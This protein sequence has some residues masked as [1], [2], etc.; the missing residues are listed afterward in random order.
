MLRVFLL[1]NT[2]IGNSKRKISSLL[3]PDVCS[4]FSK[5]LLSVNTGELTTNI[6]PSINS[7]IVKNDKDSS[8]TAASNQTT[9]KPLPK[10]P[11]RVIGVSK[12]W[13]SAVP[14]SN[15]S[16]GW[17]ASREEMVQWNLEERQKLYEEFKTPYFKDLAEIKREG[18]KLWEAIPVLIKE[19][20]AKYMPNMK[21]RSLVKNNINTTEILLGKTS[22]VTFCFNK[23]GE[24]HVK[25]FTDPFLDAFS[26]HPSIQLVSPTHIFVFKDV[27]Y[28]SKLL[29]L[30]SARGNVFLADAKCLIRW[31]AHGKAT[32]DEINSMIEVTKILDS[33]EMSTTSNNVNAIPALHKCG[34]QVGITPFRNTLLFSITD[35]VGALD[36]CLAA[37]KS[38]NISLKRIE[39]RPSKTPEW[40]YEF[41]I[42]FDAESREQLTNVVS[43]L[44][45]IARHVQIISSIDSEA[46]EKYVPWF[47]RK[48]A[49]LDTFAEKVLEMGEELTSDHPGAK[50]PVYRARRAEIT[51]IAKTHRHGQPIP[52]IE[53]TKEEVETW[54]TVFRN[55]AKL[56]PTHA[57]REHQ[58]VFPLLVENCRYR[59][60][61]IPQLEDISRFLKDCTGFTLRPVMGLLTSRDFLNGLAFRVFHST[62]YI[63]HHSK[64]LYTPE[65]DICHELLGHANFADF[66]QE[67]GL[68][69]LGASD[70]DIEK[71]ATIYWFTV[72]FGLCRQ[73]GEIRAYGAGLLSSFG[74]LEYAL[75]DKPEK[76]PF[77]PSKTAV[78]K[79]IVT[80]YQP[81]YFV[82]ESFKDAQQKVRD[83][84]KTLTRPFSVRYN[85][86]TESVE[87]LDDKVKILRFAQNIKSDFQ[88]LLDSLES[89]QC[90]SAFLKTCIRPKCLKQFSLTLKPYSYSRDLISFQRTYSKHA[91]H[92]DQFTEIKEENPVKL[93][94]LEYEPPRLH[95]PHESPPLVIL[96]GLFGSK[97]NWKSLAKAFAQRLNTKDLRN[98]GESP[99]SPVHTYKAMAKD[100]AEFLNEHKLRKTVIIGHSMGGKVAMTMA[101]LQV[102]HIEKLVVVDCAPTKYRLSL[103]FATYITAMKKIEE[104]VVAKQ[105]HADKILQEDIAIRQFLL[106]NLK[107]DSDTG[108]YK[109]RIPLDLLNDNLEEL[110]GFPFDSAHHTFRK[111]TL[112]IVGTKSNYVKPKVHSTIRTLFPEAVIV[113]IE[114]GHWVH[115][116]KPQEFLTVVSDFAKNK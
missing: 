68:A 8:P 40:D 94:F 44:Q 32:R 24:D 2:L 29:E 59:E 61:N 34:P 7:N 78:Q 52:R 12:L 30:N 64:P 53:Y 63:R 49:D 28:I 13:D 71:L 72:E 99:H 65:P 20:K 103:D 48:K 56:F 16:S 92:Q 101:L 70:S 47:P 83:Y 111:P 19:D 97:Q 105:S 96:H 5:R 54:A 84:A 85:P 108:I 36:E 31:M 74:E 90:A 37:I 80:E 106:T 116:E 95:A 76:K 39:S 26:E 82:A 10:P 69:S 91:N 18:D 42:D 57:C 33:R 77:E 87:V 93:E 100:V 50:D 45:K 89:L 81:L 43:E 14:S 102:P 73:D 110:G 115:A 4:F 21:G 9:K 51:R 98:H 1:K 6:S 66:S 113:D 88:N 3:Q 60:D 58:Y 112:F 38:L 86:Y 27:Y 41:F 25:T 67:I 75:T 35:R 46:T 79:Y 55:L 17:L 114:A 22:L 11:N 15:R 107:K 23:F 109:F 62:Q 104:T